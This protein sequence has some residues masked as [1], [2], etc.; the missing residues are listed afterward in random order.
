MYHMWYMLMDFARKKTFEDQ[1][2]FEIVWVFR[3]SLFF[4]ERFWKNLFSLDLFYLFMWKNFIEISQS[5]TSQLNLGSESV[6]KRKLKP[7][8]SWKGRGSN[9]RFIWNSLKKPEETTSAKFSIQNPKPNSLTPF[10]SPNI[11]ANPGC[12]HKFVLIL[13]RPKSQTLEWKEVFS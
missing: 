11:P 6:M 13:D 2:G 8:Y 3:F 9:F 12:R 5:K 10:I 4:P 1:T 7:L